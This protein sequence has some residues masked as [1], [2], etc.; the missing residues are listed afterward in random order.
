MGKSLIAKIRYKGLI[1]EFYSYKSLRKFV[2]EF[3]QEQL[4]QPKNKL[5]RPI[6]KPIIKKSSILIKKKSDGE[7]S[8]NTKENL[9]FI[10]E[11]PWL[12]VLNK[13]G[14]DHFINTI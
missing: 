4:K 5:P 14:K 9:D 13:R 10:Q 1:I 11:N 8:C 2:Q 6:P 12:E 3:L 7:F